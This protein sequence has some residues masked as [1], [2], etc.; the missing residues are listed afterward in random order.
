MVGTRRSCSASIFTPEQQ[1]PITDSQ[2]RY[3]VAYLPT[4]ETDT[5]SIDGIAFDPYSLTPLFT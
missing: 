1:I 2:Y 5:I 4:L 3:T